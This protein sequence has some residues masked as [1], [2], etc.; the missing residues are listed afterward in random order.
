MQ[1]VADFHLHSKY[2][3]AVSQNMTIRTMAQMA[4]QK[5]IDLITASDFT[6]PLW[7]REIKNELEEVESGIYQLKSKEFDTQFILS[8]EISCIYSQNG[9]GRRIHNLIFA[10]NLETVEKINK[11][12]FERGFN[13]SSDGRPIIGASSKDLLEMILE[14]S[15]KCFLI[16]CHVWT[17]WFGIYGQMSGFESLSEAFGDMEKYIYGI[18]TGLSS[19]PEM[20]WRIKELENRSILSFS[21]AHSPAKMGREATVF[22]VES[23]TYE[24]VLTAIK[25]PTLNN[26][27]ETKNQTNKVIYTIEFY[28]EEGKYHYSGHRNCNISMTPEEQIAAHNI[29]PV[30]HRSLT[31][32]VMRRVDELSNFPD[33]IKTREN[34][35]KLTWYLDP[36]G[37]HPP[38]VKIVPLLEI[39][40]ESYDMLPASQKVKGVYENLVTNVAPEF[41][42]LLKTDV[43]EIKKIGESRVAEAIEKVRQGSIYIKPG[44]DGVFGVVK[45]WDEKKSE[46][47]KNE[48][49]NSTVQMGLEF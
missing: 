37:I 11:A 29:C 31:D 44:Y 46:G 4:K 34:E 21:D 15:D 38:F 43:S 30:C 12:L 47:G 10:P 2:S 28:P 26:D 6:H 19:D 20:N 17:P 16:P 24:N 5:G 49:K 13:L 42:L 3:R 22:E 1:I 23:L 48:D 25:Q 35:K 9:K 36:K 14:I 33:A 27:V 40:A 39:I 8:T 32:G 41:D 7:F 45:I 18:E